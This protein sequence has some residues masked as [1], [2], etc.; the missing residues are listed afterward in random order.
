MM[1]SD[2]V[3]KGLRS[4]IGNSGVSEAKKMDA[5][6]EVTANQTVQIKKLASLLLIYTQSDS[7]T[8]DA[9]KMAV[10][11]GKGDEALQAM[12]QS[13]FRK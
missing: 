4:Y 1:K 9:A 5:L 11:F 6:L 12:F 13:K 2:D 3:N 7:F 8:A 10:K